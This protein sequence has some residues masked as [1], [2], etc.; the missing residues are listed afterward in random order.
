V[1]KPPEA[2][3]PLN[4]FQPGSFGQSG[5]FF[6]AESYHGVSDRPPGLVTAPSREGRAKSQAPHRH[7]PHS[8]ARESLAAARPRALA[9]R[10]RCSQCCKKAAEVVAVARP[11]PRGGASR[12]NRLCLA[13]SNPET[14]GGRDE[15]HTLA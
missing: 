10:L 14:G 8:R 11:R 4:V 12:I 15:D 13:L 7:P 5:R 9:P 6:M 1:P 2:W 3:R